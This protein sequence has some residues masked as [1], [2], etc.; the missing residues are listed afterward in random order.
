MSGSGNYIGT[1]CGVVL[2]VDHGRT[3]GP[4]GRLYHLYQTEPILFSG[5]TE[6]VLLMEDFFD[7]L[8]YP[9]PGTEERSFIRPR[10]KPERERMTRVMSDDMILSKHGEIGTFIVR[11]EH[12]QH[13][14]WQG[15]VT[16]VEEQKTVPFRSVLELIK[17]IDSVC[18]ED[19]DSESGEPEQS[20]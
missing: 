14:S 7:R 20:F 4:E 10:K 12:R 16:W 3:R 17:L 8:G 11:V 6:A 5:M 1:P 9:F 19:K 2:C 15:R 13:S 18:E